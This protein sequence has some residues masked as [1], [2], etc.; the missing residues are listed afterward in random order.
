MHQNDPVD[1]AKYGQENEFLGE[2][3]WKRIYRCIKSIKKFDCNIKHARMFVA[4]TTQQYKFD[5][6]E[7]HDKNETLN[8]DKVNKNSLWDTSINI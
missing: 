5:V 4:C 7:P 8:F 3:D 2:T 1:L 6:K